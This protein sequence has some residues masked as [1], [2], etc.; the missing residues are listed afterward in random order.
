MANLSYNIEN[1]LLRALRVNNLQASAS[2]LVVSTGLKANEVEEA[3][4]VLIQERRGHMKV[5]ESGEVLYY[6]PKGLSSQVKGF[7][8]GMKSFFRMF[9]ST[10]GSILVLLFKIWIMVMLVGYFVLFLAILV[11]AVLASLAGS[12]S[13][14]DSRDSRS[15]N[16]GM[17]GNIGFYISARIFGFLL[18][19]WLYSSFLP[20]EKTSAQPK[21]PFHLAV[22]SF[23]F[24]AKDGLKAWEDAMNRHLASRIVQGKGIITLDEIQEI[25]GLDRERSNALFS[26][27]LLDHKGEPMVSDA[28][29]LYG[30]FPNLLRSLTHT[31]SSSSLPP[32]PEKPFSDNT[33]GI[34]PW[35]IFFNLFNLFFGSY[36]T[37]YSFNTFNSEGVNFIGD[38][39]KVVLAK[40]L[41][42]FNSSPLN[43]MVLGLVP[44]IFSML[45]FLIPI[46][47]RIQEGGTNKKIRERNFRRELAKRVLSSPASIIV[48]EK[49]Q[50][51]PEKILMDLAESRKLEVDAQG[52]GYVFSLPDLV[53]EKADLTELRN[54]IKISDYTM[55]KTVFDSGQ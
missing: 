55:G 51:Q 41:P 35:I 50:F 2:D 38:L 31:T 21:R 48:P 20:R 30:W 10:L 49:T 36:F 7:I 4:P 29:T 33:K 46:L 19:L 1:R 3:L 34:N 26:R 40:V 32:C 52:S 5:T 11:L 37:L 47:R 23:V 27:L 8:P 45:F 9:F 16:S 6:F 28:G 43:L 13:N 24:G 12:A 42:T 17:G 53:R 15:S 25:S 39:V 14:K 54:K 22:F 44:L 18:N